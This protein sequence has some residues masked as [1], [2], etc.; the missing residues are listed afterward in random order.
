MCNWCK[1]RFNQYNLLKVDHILS[2][3]LG[4]KNEWKNIQLLHRHCHY[5]KTA[6]DKKKEKE[7]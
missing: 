4:G 7:G 6:L 3:K 5:N 2:L 1:L